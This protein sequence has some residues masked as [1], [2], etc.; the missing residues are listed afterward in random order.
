M[1][2]FIP[3]IA[4]VFLATA[5]ATPVFAQAAIQEPGAFAFYHPDADVLA[6]RYA[7]RRPNRMHILARPCLCVIAC[8]SRRGI[9]AHRDSGYGASRASEWRAVSAAAGFERFQRLQQLLGSLLADA[10]TDA[11]E[12]PLARGRHQRHGPCRHLFIYRPGFLGG[13]HPYRAIDLG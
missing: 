13:G 7:V 12:R 5:I 10:V 4:G 9:V 3:A 1:T 11:F 6:G 8:R 2:K